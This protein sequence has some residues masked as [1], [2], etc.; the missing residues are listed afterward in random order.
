MFGKISPPANTQ[1]YKEHKKHKDKSMLFIFIFSW[2]YRIRPSAVH[3]PFKP[4]EQGLMKDDWNSVHP[5]PNQ[6]GKTVGV[7]KQ[8]SVYSLINKSDPV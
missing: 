2:L 8:C 4:I 6:V 1:M 3:K 7:D 5:N